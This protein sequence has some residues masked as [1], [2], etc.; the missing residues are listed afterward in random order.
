M[1]KLV[2]G[3]HEIMT[4]DEEFSNVQTDVRLGYD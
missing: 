2:I 3:K 1:G 4:I